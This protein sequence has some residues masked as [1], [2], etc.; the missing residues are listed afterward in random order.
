MK[1]KKNKLSCSK[2]ELICSCLWQLGRAWGTAPVVCAWRYVSE[3][4]MGQGMEGLKGD[5]FSVS[6]SSSG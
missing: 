5:L 6:P 4:P 3:S 2:E 1:K